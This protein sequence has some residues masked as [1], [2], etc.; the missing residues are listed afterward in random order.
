MV[1]HLAKFYRNYLRRFQ[2]TKSI[3]IMGGALCMLA[4]VLFLSAGAAEAQTF[5]GTILGT[6]TDS[7]GA[8]IAGATVTV[9][10]AD[11]GLTRTVITTDDGSYAA[12]ELP[13]GNY[14][15]SVEKSGFKTGSVNGIRVEVS[16]ER[17]ADVALQAGQVAESVIVSAETLPQVE[18]TENTLGGIIQSKEVT[19]LPVNGAD[20]QKLIFLVPGVAGS[21]DEVADS[22]G[23]YG[24]FSVNGA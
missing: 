7:S 5:R 6:V 21:P 12:P 10:N 8:A 11:T 4:M 23:S 22:S 3:R 13:I 16:S 19:E 9:K 2:M 20:Y 14:N 24:T 15:V 1:G 18:S 17:R